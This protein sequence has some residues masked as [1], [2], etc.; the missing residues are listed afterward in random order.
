MKIDD[1]EKFRPKTYD[2]RLSQLTDIYLEDINKIPYLDL[3]KLY[4]EYYNE[5]IP[6]KIE[7]NKIIFLLTDAEIYDFYRKLNKDGILKKYK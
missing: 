2:E 7:N 6:Y 1:I 4:S 3:I 5:E